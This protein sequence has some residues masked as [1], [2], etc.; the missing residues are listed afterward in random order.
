MV[1]PDKTASS[2]LS[3]VIEKL[4]LCDPKMLKDREDGLVGVADMV[5]KKRNSR[6]CYFVAN[7]AFDFFP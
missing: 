7:F 3:V 2:T 5:L 4:V 6:L 1:Q